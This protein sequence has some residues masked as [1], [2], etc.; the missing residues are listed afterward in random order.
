VPA[1]DHKASDTRRGWRETV[2]A[3]LYRAHRVGCPSSRDRREG[4]RCACPWQ[5]VVPGTRPG[6][7]RLVRVTGTLSEARAERRRLLAAGRQPA[8]KPQSDVVTLDAFAAQYLRAKSAVLAPHTIAGTETDYRLRVSPALGQLPLEAINR[9]V[10]EVWVAEVVSAA[11]SRRMVVQA[12]AALR[13]VLGLAVEWGR[14]PVNPAARLRLPPSEAH[15][16]QAA[17]RVLDEQQLG[18][19]LDR[20]TRLVRVETMLRAAAEGG[21]RRGEIIA[22]R[23]PDVDLATRRLE[24]RRSVWQVGSERGEKTAKG[25]RARRVAISEAFAARLGAWYAESVVGGGGDASGLVWPG[26]QGRHMDAHSP[27]QAV[28][29][30]VIRAGLVD[31]TGQPLVTLHGLRHTCGSI[32]LARGVPLIVVSRHLGHADPNVTAK[33]YAH[34]LNDAQL[35]QAADVFGRLSDAQTLRETLREKASSSRTRS[36]K[37]I[38]RS[39]PHD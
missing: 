27:T 7:T 34:L 5:I 11:S 9:E 37:R 3:G 13:A 19:L 2:E 25:R 20:G 24:I 17:E 8:P 18:Q 33:V 23:W 6:S 26:R 32:L 10:V 22:L 36:D 15:R 16:E 39:A 1:S 4:R 28:G 38:T 21:L 35:D 31:R 12:V 14:I 30:A 29:R